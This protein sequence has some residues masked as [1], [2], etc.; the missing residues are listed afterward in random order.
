MSQKIP[1]LSIIARGTKQFSRYIVAKADEYKNPM[2]WTGEGWDDDESEAQMFFDA[3]DALWVL[4]EEMLG[5]L[6][7]RPARS[8]SPRS[9]LK[10]L[11]QNPSS[12]H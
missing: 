3:N 2:Y 5:H 1:M 10:S 9:K 8:T 4:H 11:E 12:A 6:S 7:D